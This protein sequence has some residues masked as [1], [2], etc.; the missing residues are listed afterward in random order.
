MK[1]SAARGLVL[2]VLLAGPVRAGGAGTAG[3]EFL[4]ISPSTRAAGMGEAYVGLADDIGALSI[5]PGG[6]VR[7]QDM[8]LH[9]LHAFW[10]DSIGY[11]YLS[12]LAPLGR[13]GTAGVSLT[14]L[15][16]QDQRI[17]VGPSGEPI[18]QGNFDSSEMAVSLGWA[19]QIDPTMSAGITA[20]SLSSKFDDVSSNAFA[21]DLGLLYRTPMPELTSG[22]AITNLGSKLGNDG[23]PV[24]LKFGGSYAMAGVRGFAAMVSGKKTRK[25]LPILD[26]D[27]LFQLSPQQSNLF[28][29]RLGAEYDIPVNDAQNVAL[30]AGYRFGEV[31]AGGLFGASFGMGYRL[32]ADR[33]VLGIDYAFG[34]YGDLGVTHRLAFTTTFQHRSELSYSETAEQARASKREGQAFVQWPTSPD[35]QVTGYNVYMGEAKDADFVKV[36]RTGAIHGTSLTLKGLKIG[37]TYY[38]F[39]TTVIGVDP[40][41]EGRPFFETSAQAQPVP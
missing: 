9:Y 14:R 34:N 17:V 30:R 33:F 25:D 2:A 27:V 39:V 41:I 4:A 12:A 32:T 13:I 20:K 15:Y 22:L 16:L 40:A 18:Q 7:A 5:N 11:D 26:A 10:L 19:Y 1:G 3:G 24:V 31:G 29:L 38:F 23:L 28:R 8:S 37:K 6:L 35:P 36:N 21:A